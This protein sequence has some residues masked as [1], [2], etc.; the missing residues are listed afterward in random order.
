MRP[1][2]VTLAAFV[3]FVVIAGAVSV[4]IRLGSFELPP[5]WAATLRYA[6]AVLIFAALAIALHIPLPARREPRW[7]HCCSV[8]PSSSRPRSCT[9]A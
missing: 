2:R 4:A 8:S 3:G 1:D 7:A 6:M 9:W 5:F